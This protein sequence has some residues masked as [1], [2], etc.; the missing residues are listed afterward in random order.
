M[1]LEVVESSTFP[2]LDVKP[3]V[4]CGVFS[5]FPKLVF[6]LQAVATSF[7]IG[8]GTKDQ[9]VQTAATRDTNP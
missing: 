3:S 6:D 8:F 1:D 9:A 7:L 2:Y 5:E 4:A